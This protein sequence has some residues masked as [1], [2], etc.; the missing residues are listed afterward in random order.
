MFISEYSRWIYI[1]IFTHKFV[2]YNKM[3]TFHRT[4]RL[5]LY[6]RAEFFNKLYKNTI[7]QYCHM[8]EYLIRQCQNDPVCWLLSVYT[9]H[10]SRVIDNISDPLIKLKV[11]KLFKTITTLW[12][13]TWTFGIMFWRFTAEYIK[14]ILLFCGYNP[15]KSV[16]PRV[17]HY[18]RTTTIWSTT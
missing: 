10:V 2:C 3:L 5:T 14:S 1:I 6:S 17:P 15:D 8:N 11:Y 18:H 16:L 9:T 4:A 13:F 7:I 12:K